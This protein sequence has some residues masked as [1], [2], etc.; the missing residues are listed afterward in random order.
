MQMSAKK[1]EEP[2]SEFAQAIA[3]RPRGGFEFDITGFFGL[4]GKPLP[5]ALIRRPTSTEQERALVG[6]HDH[7]SAAAGSVE[8]AKSDEAIILD[9]KQA[10]IAYEFTRDPKTGKPLFPGPRWM[11]DHLRVEE[12]AVLVNL[13]NEVRAKEAPSRADVTNEAVEAYIDLCE[14]A[15]ETPIPGAALAGCSREY[16]TFL[17]VSMALKVRDARRER[18]TL[19]ALQRG[20]VHEEGAEQEAADPEETHASE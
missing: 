12:I 20:A 10:F 13:A 2:L 17:L 15:A 6:A 5:K 11:K 18:A 4:A 7:V 9:A 1:E 14:Q 3:E 8:Q 19:A 16:L